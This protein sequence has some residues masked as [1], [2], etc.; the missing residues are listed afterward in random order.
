MIYIGI[1]MG[2]KGG[3]AALDEGGRILHALK[4]PTIKRDDENHIDCFQVYSWLYENYDSFDEEVIIYTEK[5]HAI[6]GSAASATFNFGKTIGKTL[7]VVECLE[8][9]Y[10]EV[11]AVD[12]QKY[13]FTKYEIP[14]QQILKKG[15]KKPTRDTKKMAR[16]A[17]SKIWGMDV[18]DYIDNDGII[19]ALLIAEFARLTHKENNNGN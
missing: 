10:V 18:F 8:M 9:E 11:R 4:M 15:N 2:I 19:D 5:L 1:D 7:G 13:I 3:L 6:F 14:E 17:A 12:W 16:I